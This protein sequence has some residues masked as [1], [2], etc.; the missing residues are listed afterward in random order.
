MKEKLFEEATDFV[1]KVDIMH[2]FGQVKKTI[3]RNRAGKI[4]TIFTFQDFIEKAKIQNHRSRR[5]S[6]PSS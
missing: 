2:I 6:K 3:W 1:K 4:L 5:E